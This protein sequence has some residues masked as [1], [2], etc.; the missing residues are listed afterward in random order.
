MQKNSLRKISN[1]GPLY[2]NLKL[3]KIGQKLPHPS[4][5]SITNVSLDEYSCWS[6]HGNTYSW[7]MRKRNIWF[8]P[9]FAFHNISV[10]FRAS[11]KEYYIHV[12]KNCLEAVTWADKSNLSY[13]SK[14]VS[15]LEQLWFFYSTFIKI[16]TFYSPFFSSDGVKILH[17]F[18][19]S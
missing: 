8:S 14:N 11:S 17:S 16:E 1:I 19:I 13:R 5:G 2:V 12:N 15:D 4:M 10:I 6:G 3:L 7:L 9:D 18:H